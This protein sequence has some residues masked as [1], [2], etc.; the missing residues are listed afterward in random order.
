[1]QPSF[2][3]CISLSFTFEF[4]TVIH[5]IAN[6]RTNKKHSKKTNAP[7]IKTVSYSVDLPSSLCHT[8]D[9]RAR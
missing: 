9:L 1:M 6:R 3:F 2:F 8:P 5:S 4:P 7:N